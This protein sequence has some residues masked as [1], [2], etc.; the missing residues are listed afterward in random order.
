ML[1]LLELPNKDHQLHKAMVQNHY[2]ED[3]LTIGEINETDLDAIRFTTRNGDLV[4]LLPGSKSHIRA[5][6]S[7]IRHQGRKRIFYYESS[8][9][10]DITP[11]EF[12]Q[13]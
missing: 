10:L 8:D 5:Y 2:H 3:V 9:I 11:H 12:K 4:A 13:Y 6:T 1:S 7:F